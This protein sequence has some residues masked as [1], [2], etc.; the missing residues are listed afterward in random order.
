MKPYIC[1]VLLLLAAAPLSAQ[2]FTLSGQIRQHNT[3]LPVKLNIPVVF[4]YHPENTLT[5]PVDATG[6]FRITVPVDGPRFASLIYRRHFYTVLME[7]G[8]SLQV[9]LD[10]TAD[11]IRFTGGNAATA[12]RLIRHIGMDDTPFFWEN[13]SLAGLPADDIRKLVVEPYYSQSGTAA[14]SVVAAELPVAVKHLLISELQYLH[15]N[16]LGDFFSTSVPDRK[17]A[18]ELMAGMFDTIPMHPAPSHPGPQ[19]F[20]Y[21]DHFVRYLEIKSAQR[22]QQEHLASSDP[23]PY[24]GISMDSA[25]ALM[26]RYGKSYLRWIGSINNLPPAVA[27]TYNWQQFQNQYQ[28][29]DITQALALAEVFPRQFPQSL[30]NTSIRKMA[31]QLQAR[32]RTNTGN[33]R[34]AI[35]DGNEKTA[36]IYDVVRKLKGKVVYLDMWGT[37]CGPCKEEIRHLP[38]LRK[39]LAG[40]DV[41]FLFLAMEEDTRVKA[42]EDFIRVNNMEGLH[43]R[44]NRQT[45]A[46]IWKEL[47]AEHP[48]KSEYYP[49]YFLFDKSG[50]LAVAKA[51]RPSNA[52]EL[53]NQINKLLTASAQ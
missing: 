53:I 46:P 42:W 30:H 12:C 51:E 20:A 39:A 38:A 3:E 11:T 37:W 2:T 1:L 36:S 52:S 23:L 44:K 34:I 35:L 28:D 17:V 8:S 14:Q 43:F 47:L 10:A 26:N 31:G 33:E 22:M 18:R 24:F 50:K 13:D 45:I 49:Q 25:V 29:G 4:G 19:Y 41:V 32:M 48:D 5:V 7:P 40:K 16:Y 27:E 9:E 15:R 21:V 6:A